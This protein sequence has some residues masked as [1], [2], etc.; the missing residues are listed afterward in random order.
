MM[1]FTIGSWALVVAAL[2]ATGCAIPVSQD[3]NTKLALPFG[4]VSPTCAGEQNVASADG[5]THATFTNTLANQRCAVGSLVVT[6]LFDMAKVRA[7]VDTTLTA[8]GLDPKTVKVGI[9]SVSL[10][11][12]SARI[13][14][15]HGQGLPAVGIVQYRGGIGAPDQA[16]VTSATM[17]VGSDPAEPTLMGGE[18]EALNAAAASAYAQGTPLTLNGDATLVLDDRQLQPYVGVEGAALELSLAVHVE[19]HAG[20]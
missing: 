7:Q 3:L 20:L 11:T 1:R 2:S 17:E 19:G 9:D 5:M 15:A 18:S 6:Q 8:N 4:A 13:I 10:T 14:D 12:T 16:D